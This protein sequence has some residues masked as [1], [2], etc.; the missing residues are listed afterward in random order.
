MLYKLPEVLSYNTDMNLTLEAHKM[1][2][3][4]QSPVFLYEVWGTAR[5]WGIVDVNDTLERRFDLGIAGLPERIV[6]A[7]VALANAR[8]REAEV[9]AEVLRDYE[10]DTLETNFL[11]H[12]VGLLT[13]AKAEVTE[14][15]GRVFALKMG[16]GLCVYY[17][18]NDGRVFEN[19]ELI[20]TY[21]HFDELVLNMARSYCGG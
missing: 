20:G 8:Q 17:V 5:N 21:P 16:V 14:G 10:F 3:A 7:I 19:D 4:V 11:Q 15:N 6:D 12:V 9:Y 18:Y 2:A 13:G 1:I